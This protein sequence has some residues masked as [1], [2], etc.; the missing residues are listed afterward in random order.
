MSLNNTTSKGKDQ[1]THLRAAGVVQ[2]VTIFLISQTGF[3][4]PG[5][6]ITMVGFRIPLARFWIPKPW[7]PDST[8]QNYLDS[9]FRITLQGGIYGYIP[10][11]KRTIASL[12]YVLIR[13]SLLFSSEIILKQL[14]PSG[15]VNIDRIIIRR[16]SLRLRRIIV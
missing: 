7:I 4:Q 2:V 5:F 15:S 10:V 1:N 8:D 12:F 9:G 11:Y 14:F 13:Y 6:W 16:Y 3:Q